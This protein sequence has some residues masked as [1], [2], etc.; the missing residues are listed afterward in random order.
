VTKPKFLEIRY[1]WWAEKGTHSTGRKR[2]VAIVPE[3]GEAYDFGSRK[4]LVQM[5]KEEGI[6]YKVV[7]YHRKKGVL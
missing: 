3:T 4:E 7:V 5:A 2:S 6:D 1:E